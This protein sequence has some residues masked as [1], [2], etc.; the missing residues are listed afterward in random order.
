L[1]YEKL[2]KM[3]T[4]ADPWAYLKD[5]DEYK[6]QDTI[7]ACIES[8]EKFHVFKGDLYIRR[9]RR[10][11]PNPTININLNLQ[12]PPGIHPADIPSHLQQ[13]IQRIL[14]EGALA[15]REQVI[16]ELA[17]QSPVERIEC[18]LIGGKWVEVTS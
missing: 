9:I 2:L 7:I 14:Q 4:T 13:L 18:R 6:E 15:I 8:T 1:A 5:Q 11:P 16:K 17:R 12:L 3:N 10:I